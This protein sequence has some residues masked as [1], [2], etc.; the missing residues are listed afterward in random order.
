[1]DEVKEPQFIR[2]SARKI[3][4]K[5]NQPSHSLGDA[6][7]GYARQIMS[8]IE[9]EGA[10]VE[11]VV[12]TFC[13]LSNWKNIFPDLI[14]VDKKEKPFDKI[15]ALDVGLVYKTKHRSDKK[16][17]AYKVES[18]FKDVAGVHH[19]C[20]TQIKA[21][22]FFT[23][24]RFTCQIENTPEGVKF[25]QTTD[26]TLP[27][28]GGLGLL[29]LVP[30]VMG[31]DTNELLVKVVVKSHSKLQ[32]LMH[33]PESFR[34]DNAFKE[35]I[36]RV[37]NKHFRLFHDFDLPQK[38]FYLALNKVFVE[39]ENCKAIFERFV[40]AE[41]GA[42]V[43]KEAKKIVI[44]FPYVSG[45]TEIEF[46]IDQEE[47]SAIT[48]KSAYNSPYKINIDVKL[49]KREHEN[50]T[51]CQLSVQY[52]FGGFGF[53]N[54][55]SSNI[56]VIDDAVKGFLI[57][58]MRKLVSE[59]PKIAQE[60]SADIAKP[61]EASQQRPKVTIGGRSRPTPIVAEK[62]SQEA[63]VEGEIDDIPEEFKNLMLSSGVS[64][65]NRR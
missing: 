33:N 30:Y 6:A 4:L 19:L 1:M 40:K 53:W 45:M 11:S 42:E 55:A 3:P 15:A 7:E 31:I 22:E 38:T 57:T 52:D 65:N 20:V 35:N 60:F 58:T 47:S 46:N 5:K 50:T 64:L 48:L 39:P 32:R 24:M 13:Q 44:E 21:G 49:I 61:K 9:I 41:T 34:L 63:R 2:T 18:N 51:Q 25:K 8:G 56:P 59:I 29:N 43:E 37:E 16:F 10:D 14:L 12:S 28:D 54:M 27:S 26:Y 23:E 17:A 62:L 36:E